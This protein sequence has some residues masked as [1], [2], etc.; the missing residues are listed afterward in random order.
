M[1]LLTKLT[2]KITAFAWEHEIDAVNGMAMVDELHATPGKLKLMVTQNPVIAQ[3]IA[4]SFANLV[5]SSKNYTELKFETA[6]P[7]TSELITV[8]VKKYDGKTPHELRIE[9]EQ[10]LEV[11]LKRI[12]ELESCK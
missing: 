11:A 10:K 8:L 12:A 3:F 2:R 9:A 7:D 6:D 4:L 5:H 1:N